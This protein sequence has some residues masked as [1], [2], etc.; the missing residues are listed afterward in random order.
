V[1]A[2]V[3]SVER[4]GGTAAG[5]IAG[6]AVGGAIGIGVGIYQACKNPDDCAKLYANIDDAVNRLK[7][8]HYQLFE[9]KLNSPPSGPFSVG[10]HGGSLR[11]DLKLP[12]WLTAYE[13][14]TLDL[15]P[16]FFDCDLGWPLGVDRCGADCDRGGG[17]RVLV[18]GFLSTPS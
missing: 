14:S 12:V 17:G 4:G 6:A 13:T 9:N 10:T 18:G 1:G 16:Y 11:G 7:R 8:R 15:A 2:E 5:A 3:G